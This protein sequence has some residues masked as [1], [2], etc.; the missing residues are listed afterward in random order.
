MFTSFAEA[1]YA[2]R[3]IPVLLRKFPSQHNIEKDAAN[4]PPGELERSLLLSE[5][6]AKNRRDPHQTAIP[7][8]RP[9]ESAI[10]TV[11]FSPTG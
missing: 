11:P 1:K 6:L 2:F 3:Q 8:Q 10:H 9:G 7:L 5:S 4:V